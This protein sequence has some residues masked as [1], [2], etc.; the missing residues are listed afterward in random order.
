MS[1][2]M[3]LEFPYYESLANA[4]L[5]S[6]V[7]DEAGAEFVM[8]YHELQLE[9]PPHMFWRDGQPVEELHGHYS[10]RRL[11]FSDVKRVDCEGV[12]ADLDNTPLDHSARYLQGAL[13]WKPTLDATPFFLLLASSPDPAKLFLSAERV[14]LETRQGD[15]IPAH[16]ARNWSP[17]PSWTK[18]LMAK[19]TADQRDVGGNRI[20]FKL[21]NTICEDKLFVGGIHFQSRERPPVDAVLNLSEERSNWLKDLIVPACDRWSIRGEGMD[22]MSNDDIVNEAQWVVERLREGQRVLVHCSAGFNRS[23]TVCCAALI[24]MENLSAEEALA[25]VR[26]HHPWSRPDAYHWLKLKWLAHN[27][28]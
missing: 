21:N 25:R 5:D 4:R 9:S 20:H 13:Y 24:L 16:F 18:R 10:P 23:V 1:D 6:V 11:R 8:D 12:Y 7:H 26:E 28:I 22:G 15:P 2:A 17:A 27:G 14:T 3:L 19:N